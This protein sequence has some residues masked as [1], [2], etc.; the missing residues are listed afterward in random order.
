MTKEQ[1]DL[2]DKTRRDDV[3][4]DINQIVDRL[5][6]LPVFPS[7]A[8]VW[9]WDIVRSYYDSHQ[10]DDVHKMQYEEECIAQGLELKTIWDKFWEDSD[11]NG[12]SLEYGALYV[13]EAVTDWMRECGFIVSLDEDS[14]LD[15]DEEDDGSFQ[16]DGALV[17]E[18]K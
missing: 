3:Y 9:C 5:N 8:W 10:W 12:F 13:D 11:K 2:Q 15:E 18:G 1:P 16:M 17:S 4:E 7:L 6:S 14:W